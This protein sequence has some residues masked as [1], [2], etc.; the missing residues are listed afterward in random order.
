MRK[1][2]NMGSVYADALYTKIKMNLKQNIGL[3]IGI[4]FLTIVQRLCGFVVVSLKA[5]KRYYIFL[6]PFIFLSK[7]EDAIC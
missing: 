4:V 6:L 1:L 5:M 7:K 3:Q 2:V